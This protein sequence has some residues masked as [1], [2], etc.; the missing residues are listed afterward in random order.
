MSLRTIIHLR[1]A[2]ASFLRVSSYT[3]TL[4]ASAMS[5][6]KYYPQG[7]ENRRIQ[8]G[9]TDAT[10]KCETIYAAYYKYIF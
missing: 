2:G 4:T 6:I 5:A 3:T 1:A 10:K 9:K 8:N 7:E